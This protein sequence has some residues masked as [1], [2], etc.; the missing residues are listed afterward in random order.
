MRATA[1]LESQCRCHLWLSFLCPD[2]PRRVSRSEA[3]GLVSAELLCPYPPGIP[4][5][6]P[7]EV[8][9]HGTLEILSSAVACGGTVTGASDPSLS[10]LLVLAIDP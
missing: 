2:A 1:F 6:V 10:S 7:G 3:V 4:A 5:V 8:L 9:T